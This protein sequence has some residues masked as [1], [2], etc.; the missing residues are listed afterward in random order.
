MVK[1][2]RI[3]GNPCCPIGTIS[4]MRRLLGQIPYSDMPDTILD[5]SK[6]AYPHFYY[7]VLPE[8]RRITIITFKN[9]EN[10]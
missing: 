2:Y 7:T 5:I 1:A 3:E 6:P 4:T 9:P 10:K 8:Y